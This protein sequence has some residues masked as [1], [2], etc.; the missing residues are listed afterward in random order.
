AQEAAQQLGVLARGIAAHAALTAS[1]P[2]ETSEPF[3]RSLPWR[4]LGRRRAAMGDPTAGIPRSASIVAERRAPDGA[5]PDRRA[6]RRFVDPP[7]PASRG[8]GRCYVAGPGGWNVPC[9][10]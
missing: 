3:G 5:R 10:V 1:C 6:S 7:P 2:S 4:A 9:R 8:R